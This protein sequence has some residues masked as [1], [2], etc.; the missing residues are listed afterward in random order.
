M[1]CSPPQ[2]PLFPMSCQLNVA[3]QLP[4]VIVPV[5]ES[6]RLKLL[7]THDAI[8][9]ENIKARHSGLCISSPLPHLLLATRFWAFVVMNLNLILK[10]IQ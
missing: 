6:L 4:A 9:G 10:M 1:F 7:C 2:L 3:C 5:L 8:Q